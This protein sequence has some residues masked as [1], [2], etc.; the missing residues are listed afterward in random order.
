MAM[1]IG[2]PVVGSTTLAAFVDLVY[3]NKTAALTGASAVFTPL[4]LNRVVVSWP[5]YNDVLY[6]TWAA[7]PLLP[8]TISY[9]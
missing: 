2:T 8:E 5:G 9:S 7:R 6:L 3:G 4:E 1:I